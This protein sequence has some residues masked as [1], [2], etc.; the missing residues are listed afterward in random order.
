MSDSVIILTFKIM[1]YQFVSALVM[2]GLTT[3]KTIP[4]G[5][6]GKTMNLH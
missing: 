4:K 3:L 2:K 5:K 6:S 1:H